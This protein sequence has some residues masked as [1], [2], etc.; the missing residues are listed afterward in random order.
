MGNCFVAFP[1]AD[2]E[3]TPGCYGQKIKLRSLGEKCF[4]RCTFETLRPK[5]LGVKGRV[6]GPRIG[7][8]ISAPSGK[9]REGG[10]HAVY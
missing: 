2:S 10:K 3:R 6:P 9:G 7:K 5:V 4:L 8:W 1:D